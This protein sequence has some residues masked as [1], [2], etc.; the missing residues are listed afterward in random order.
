MINFTVCQDTAESSVLNFGDQL[1][2][3]EPHILN[4][5]D[6]CNDNIFWSFDLQSEERGINGSLISGEVREVIGE[7]TY[8]NAP[9]Q[10]TTLE[11]RRKTNSEAAKRY[12]NRQ[13]QEIESMRKEIK[14]LKQQIILL[15]DALEKSSGKIKELEDSLAGHHLPNQ[16]IQISKFESAEDSPA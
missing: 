7:E 3:G 10:R 8:H 4:T 15:E 12:R 11:K 9:L 1:F 14:T 16:D 13:K 2:P 6:Y 5:K